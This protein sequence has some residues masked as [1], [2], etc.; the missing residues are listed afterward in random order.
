MLHDIL[1]SKDLYFNLL[2]D[3]AAP[4]LP[5]A[6]TELQSKLNTTPGVNAAVKTNVNNLISNMQVY[7]MNSWRIYTAAWINSTKLVRQVYQ[8]N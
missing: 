8:K 4:D 6:K 2:K 1:T 3:L 5:Q 7:Q